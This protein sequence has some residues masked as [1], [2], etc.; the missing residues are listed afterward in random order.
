MSVSRKVSRV[1]WGP[2][3]APVMP[4][5]GPETPEEELKGE[6]PRKQNLHGGKKNPKPLTLNFAFPF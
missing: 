1:S 5:S 6:V 2:P 3:Q 4:G